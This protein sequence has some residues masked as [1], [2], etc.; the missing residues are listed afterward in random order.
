MQSNP[1]EDLILRGI[2]AT[3]ITVILA[4]I[5]LNNL[6]LPFWTLMVLLAIWGTLV[7]AVLFWRG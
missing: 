5:L 6:F 3:I 2:V 4:I 1:P 7:L